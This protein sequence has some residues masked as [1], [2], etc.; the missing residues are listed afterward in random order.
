MNQGPTAPT[1]I[2]VK[3][4]TGGATT[5]EITTASPLGA[6]GTPNLV[7]SYK[8]V[9]F[10][11]TGN[12]W[13][14]LGGAMEQIQWEW[15][16][17]LNNNAQK[18]E[19]QS[20]AS[21]TGATNTIISHAAGAQGIVQFDTGSTN[22]GRANYSTGVS[23]ALRGTG[24]KLMHFHTRMRFPVLSNGTDRFYFTAG[25]FSSL[26][27]APNDG[28]YFRYDDSVSAN[29]YAVV[30]NNSTGAAGVSTGVAVATNTF[31]KLRIEVDEPNASAKF[32]I[33]DSLTNTITT[34][35]PG[36][37]RDFGIGVNMR[38]SVGTASLKADCDYAGYWSLITTTV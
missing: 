8:G 32:Y 19:L 2:E 13:W 23:N 29:W 21:G 34:N 33:D 35:F 24:D 16:H 15:T 10:M 17:F 25:F 20:N 26:T 27:A 3:D 14:P 7:R 37:T 22:A 1:T 38:K 11:D 18:G 36:S 6:P 5:G 12:Y 31:Q 28:F 9:M 30:V 4:L